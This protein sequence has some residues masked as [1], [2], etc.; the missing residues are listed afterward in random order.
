MHF[1]CPFGSLMPMSRRRVKGAGRKEGRKEGKK[2][3]EGKLWSSNWLAEVYMVTI[4][5]T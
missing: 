2:E 1:L 5:C 4:A 3:E